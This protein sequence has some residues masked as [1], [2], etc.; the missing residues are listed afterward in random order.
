MTFRH[1]L[2]PLLFIVK[3]TTKAL[4][5][6]TSLLKSSKCPTETYIDNKLKTSSPLQFIKYYG[7]LVSLLPY[8]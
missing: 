4:E 6:F 2:P 7:I 5:W 1:L 8:L 3:I